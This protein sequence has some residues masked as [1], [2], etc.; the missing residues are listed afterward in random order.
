MAMNTPSASSG[1]PRSIP[2]LLTM[3]LQGAAAL[4]QTEA[5][6]LPP[7]TEVL[8]ATTQPL[9]SAT[10]TLGEKVDLTV[11][12]D[13]LVNEQVV[14]PKGSPAVGTV[15][16]ARKKA[17]GGM[18]GAL[19]LRADYV[20]LGEQKIE[21]RSR[22][23][24]RGTDRSKSAAGL[25]AVGIGLFMQGDDVELPAGSELLAYSRKAPVSQGAQPP[26]PGWMPPPMEGKGLVFFFRA[27]DKSNPFLSH[28]KIKI[29]DQVV[30]TMQN[31]HYFY[32][33]VDP[34]EH[35][36]ESSSTIVRLFRID[37]GEVA[38]FRGS[39]VVGIW[40]SDI[41]PDVAQDLIPGLKLSA[42]P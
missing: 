40:L 31:D 24:R 10:A 9:S 38:Y 42:A 25:A 19:D 33:Y 20:S 8:L 4:A 34:G 21:L 27:K 23:G 5:P 37:A 28:Q 18:P 3:L 13:V 15:V 29:D 1:R 39:I 35:R 36:I 11:S 30:G 12:A 26:S 16:F 17:M 41:D 7:E 32:T 22:A 6:V 14:I 2:L